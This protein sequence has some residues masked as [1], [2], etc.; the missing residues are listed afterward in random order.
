MS[1]Q[2][3]QNINYNH[4]CNQVVILI[5]YTDMLLNLERKQRF[6]LIAIC[7]RILNPSKV[8]IHLLPMAD[9]FH[10]H[11]LSRLHYICFDDF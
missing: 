6:F 5:L 1:L 9:K 2:V 4:G 7:S 11:I 10:A 3:F 8:T